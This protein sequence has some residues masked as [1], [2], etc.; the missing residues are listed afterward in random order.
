MDQYI[1]VIAFRDNAGGLPHLHLNGL[2]I[3]FNVCPLFGEVLGNGR[4][5]KSKLTGCRRLR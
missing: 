3:D 1:P 4:I 5:R 2:I